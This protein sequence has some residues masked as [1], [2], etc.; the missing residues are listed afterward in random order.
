M[1]YI[2]LLLVGGNR[3][4]SVSL[5]YLEVEDYKDRGFSDFYTATN[6]LKF[7]GKNSKSISEK[8]SILYLTIVKQSF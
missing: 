5:C 1:W 6:Y 3:L 8:K 7:Y 2:K 4:S